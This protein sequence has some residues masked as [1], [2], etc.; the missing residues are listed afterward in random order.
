[1]TV[2]ERI[3]VTYKWPDIW[4]TE[5]S[6]NELVSNGESFIDYTINAGDPELSIRLPS[7]EVPTECVLQIEVEP[8]G[9]NHELSYISISGTHT[10]QFRTLS[11]LVPPTAEVT[12]IDVK[13]KLDY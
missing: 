3:S 5:R 2:E 6:C 9:T 12:T 10:D 13:V 1:M 11:L 7:Y 4:Y 8:L